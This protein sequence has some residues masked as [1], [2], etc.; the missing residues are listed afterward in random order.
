MLRLGGW[1]IDHFVPTDKKYLMLAGPHTAMADGFWMVVAGFALGIRPSFL[2]KETYI[3]GIMGRIILRVGGIPV[4]A[5]AGKNKV[6]ASIDSIQAQ[7]KMVLLMAPAGTRKRTERWRSGFY[8]MGKATG[9]PIYL[10]FLDYGKRHI[11]VHPEP[12]YI[13]DDIS[14]DMDKIRA[15]YANKRG[16][17]PENE[18][19][20]RLKEEPDR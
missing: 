19:V 18:S 13:S 11:G 15:V 2:V 7:N 17:V 3:N 5:G 4:L 1:R 8:Y 20:I 9:L 6:Q 12:I 10:S 16:K 14:G